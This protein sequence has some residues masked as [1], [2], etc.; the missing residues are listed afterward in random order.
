MLSAKR[1]TLIIPEAATMSSTISV[2]ATMARSQAHAPQIHIE[3]GDDAE[4]QVM[5]NLLMQ[6][7]VKVTVP[8]TGPD[9]YDTDPTAEITREE[10]SQAAAA[11][12]AGLGLAADELGESKPEGPTTPAVNEAA[13][14]E[15]P[16]A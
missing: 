7:G 13:D 11:P 9:N 10:W 6:R 5:V 2:L 1:I 16:E 8:K 4:L 3:I 14:D 12:A 15:N